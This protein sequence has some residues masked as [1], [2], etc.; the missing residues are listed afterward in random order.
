ML[1]LTV[2]PLDPSLSFHGMA[3]FDT[4]NS[5][6]SDSASATSVE[7]VRRRTPP[8]PVPISTRPPPTIPF[9]T[10]PAFSLP[11]VPVAVS[12]P[13]PSTP[14]T[15]NYWYED[16]VPRLIGWIPPVQIPFAGAEPIRPPFPGHREM[17]AFAPPENNTDR[18]T[19]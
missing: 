4:L 17:P 6:L 18:M 15:A 16:D 12:T 13:V 5:Y 7:P 19:N 3:Y 14:S 2:F 9:A 1:V 11:T 8:P 10:R